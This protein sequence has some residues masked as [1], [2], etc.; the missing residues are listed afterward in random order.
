MASNGDLQFRHRCWGLLWKILTLRKP[1]PEVDQ[2]GER[3][4]HAFKK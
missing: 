4:S 1:Q 3:E 2:S